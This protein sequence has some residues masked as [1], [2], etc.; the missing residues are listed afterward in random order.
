MTTSAND[1]IGRHAITAISSVEDPVERARIAHYAIEEL[2]RV[3]DD[4]FIAARQAGRTFAEIGAAVDASAQYI[5]RIVRGVQKDTAGLAAYAFRDTAGD[6]HGKPNGLPVGE[7]STGWLEVNPV[8]PSPFAGRRLEVRYGPWVQDVNVHA[9]Q[10][11]VDGAKKATV[12]DTREVHAAL[13]PA[14]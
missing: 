9:L 4:G 6:W 13:F 14:A 3:R 11:S 10:L 7:Y 5:D 1:K 2:R 12:R 8:S